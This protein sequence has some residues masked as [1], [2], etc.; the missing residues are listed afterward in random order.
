VSRVR[1]RARL[2][3][4][5]LVPI[6][7]GCNQAL[8][9]VLSSQT[10]AAYTDEAFAELEAAKAQGSLTKAEVLATLGPPIRVID[11]SDGDV[12][13][14]RRLDQGTRT[15]NVNL[16]LASYFFPAPPFPIYFWSA[17]KIRN[18]TLMIF[19]DPSGRVRG[20]G[21]HSDSAGALSP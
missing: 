20:D 4:W 1:Q 18:D 17:T 5:L 11:E 19:F 16:S 7:L 14:Y 8:V 3:L 21:L 13:V 9:S 2:A 6:A 15:V 12:F 10:H